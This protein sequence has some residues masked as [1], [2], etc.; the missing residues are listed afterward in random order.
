LLIIA[1]DSQRF[2]KQF[3]DPIRLAA[4][5]VYVSALPYSPGET[6]LY[7][8]YAK[9]ARNSLFVSEGVSSQWTACLHILGGYMIGVHSVAISPDGRRIV[10]QSQASGLQLWDSATG[11]ELGNIAEINSWKPLDPP[12]LITVM[13]SPSG[14]RVLSFYT[15]L[16]LWNGFNLEP[17]AKNLEGHTGIITTATFSP[18][19]KYIVSGS[20]DRKLRLWD[21][22]TGAP[23]G[24]ALGG[25]TECVNTVSF[26]GDGDTLISSSDDGTI[27]IWDVS[28]R[29]LDGIP[30]R[31]HTAKGMRTWLS[32]NGLRLLS[33]SFDG[34]LRLWDKVSRELVVERVLSEPSEETIIPMTFS[35]DGTRIATG[36]GLGIQILDGMTGAPVGNALEGPSTVRVRVLAYSPDGRYIVS[37]TG[38]STIRLWD[39]IT[40]T[41]IWIDL[42]GHYWEVNCLEFSRDSRHIASA[43]NDGTVRFWDATIRAPASEEPYRTRWVSQPMNCHNTVAIS[44]DGKQVVYVRNYVL[45]VMDGPGGKLHGTRLGDKSDTIKHRMAL[46]PDGLLLAVSWLKWDSKSTLIYDISKAHWGL[47]TIIPTELN[48]VRD[49]AFS[50]DGQKLALCGS[51]DDYK[52]WAVEDS[53]YKTKVSLS[54]LAFSPDGA[55]LAS[56]SADGVVR[57]WNGATCAPI[58]E[59]LLGHGTK[60]SSV[61]FSVDGR[62]LVSTSKE[63]MKDDAFKILCWDTE[64]RL[65]VEPTTVSIDAGVLILNPQTHWA[66]GVDGRKFWWVPALNRGVKQKFTRDGWFIAISETGRLSR[67]DGTKLVEAEKRRIRGMPHQT[68]K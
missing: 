20:E 26:S 7:E 23:I 24:S 57:L 12:S 33:T 67:I 48:V 38:S 29:S 14:K 22:T 61:L 27:R 15:A 30:L 60:V 45:Y 43:S 17:I 6:L 52:T 63:K 37:S 41:P 59:P 1:N 18:D 2:V 54:C 44:A 34:N 56:G 42:T 49:I 50:P 16:C 31:A 5:H 51:Y 10:S 40:G 47:K 9:E 66:E 3:R 35:A 13:F 39:A 58:G 36:S 32:P 21:G 68:G 4:M 55:Q 65:P 53:D 46:S 19:G 11:F 28:T 8:V 25:H 62:I 64:T